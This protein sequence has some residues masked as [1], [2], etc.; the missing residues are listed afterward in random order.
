MVKAAAIMDA[1]YT[2]WLPC[3]ISGLNISGLTSC[4]VFITAM[5]AIVSF[6][7][8]GWCRWRLCTVPPDQALPLG[9]RTEQALPDRSTC[10]L[11]SDPTLTEMHLALLCQTPEA[12][13]MDWPLTRAVNSNQDGRINHSH[14]DRARHDPRENAG[15]EKHGIIHDQMLSVTPYQEYLPR[16]DQERGHE[17]V[18][19]LNSIEKDIPSHHQYAAMGYKHTLPENYYGTTATDNTYIPTMSETRTDFLE[20]R[21]IACAHNRILS[22]NSTENM[23]TNNNCMLTFN[24]QPAGSMRQVDIITVR[25]VY[26]SIYYAQKDDLLYDTKESLSC[27]QNS[28]STFVNQTPYSSNHQLP[29]LMS[30]Y[31]TLTKGHESEDLN[32]F[33]SMDLDMS[34]S[35]NLTEAAL[36]HCPTMNIGQDFSACYEQTRATQNVDFLDEEKHFVSFDQKDT[37]S[38][39]VYS[40][41]NDQMPCVYCTE[42]LDSESANQ[43]TVL[44]RKNDTPAFYQTYAMCS[45]QEEMVS[46]RNISAVSYNQ[47]E[48]SISGL[49]PPV[50][51]DP[52]YFIS[53]NHLVPI[54]YGQEENIRFE[55]SDGSSRHPEPTVDC[56]QDL[57]TNHFQE[58]AATCKEDSLGNLLRSIDALLALEAPTSI[59]NDREVANATEK[60]VHYQESGTQSPL[61]NTAGGADLSTLYHDTA[62]SYSWLSG[63]G[64]NQDDFQLNDE[65]ENISGTDAFMISYHQEEAKS[66]SQRSFSGYDR[67]DLFSSVRQAKADG[68]FHKDDDVC[69]D[70]DEER[71]KDICHQNSQVGQVQRDAQSYEKSAT[72]QSLSQAMGMGADD[73]HALGDSFTPWYIDIVG[74]DQTD[75]LD[76]FEKDSFHCN[77]EPATDSDYQPPSTFPDDK[78]ANRQDQQD[79]FIYHLD[80]DD[81]STNRDLNCNLTDPFEPKITLGPPKSLD[82]SSG[83]LADESSTQKYLSLD[84][85]TCDACWGLKDDLFVKEIVLSSDGQSPSK[86]C[87]ESLHVDYEHRYIVKDGQKSS[88]NDEQQATSSENPCSLKCNREDNIPSELLPMV[89]FEANYVPSNDQRLVINHDQKVNLECD[90]QDSL[91]P[92]YKSPSLKSERELTTSDV[93]EEFVVDHDYYLVYKKTSSPCNTPREATCDTGSVS[94][95]TKQDAASYLVDPT[96]SL[97]EETSICDH[98]E[99]LKSSESQHDSNSRTADWASLSTLHIGRNTEVG[100]R[101]D[102]GYMGRNKHEDET[103]EEQHYLSLFQRR[104]RSPSQVSK[105]NSDQSQVGSS[106][107]GKG[108]VEDVEDYAY[109]G[110]L[111]SARYSDESSFYGQKVDQLNDHKQTATNE[112]TPP[113]CCEQDDMVKTEDVFYEDQENATCCNKKNN[114]VQKPIALLNDANVPSV[115]CSLHLSVAFD[116]KDQVFSEH[117]ESSDNGQISAKSEDVDI[118]TED[119]PALLPASKL[120]VS[121]D[122]TRGEL[123]EVQEH[124]FT[125][126]Q[127]SKGFTQQPV[128]PEE[129]RDVL[130]YTFKAGDQV[131]LKGLRK[132]PT[133]GGKQVITWKGPYNICKIFNNGMCT[134][135]NKNRK[136]KQKHP[137]AD[138]QPFQELEQCM[139]VT[140]T[141]EFQECMPSKLE[142]ITSPQRCYGNSRQN[143]VSKG[144][145]S[146]DVS[147]GWNTENE[148]SIPEMY[149][150]QKPTK[151]CEPQVSLSEYHEEDIYDQNRIVLSG[152]KEVIAN[153]NTTATCTDVKLSRG[154]TEKYRERFDHQGIVWQ[155]WKDA[156]HDEMR[157][158]VR[159]DQSLPASPNYKVG[160]QVFCKDASRSLSKRQTKTEQWKGPYVI[161]RILQNNTVQLSGKNGLLRQKYPFSNL[162]PFQTP[163]S[164]K[165]TS[166]DSSHTQAAQAERERDAEI[167]EQR[168]TLNVDKIYLCPDDRKHAPNLINN[169]ATRNQKETRFNLSQVLNKV[170]YKHKADQSFHWDDDTIVYDGKDTV[171]DFKGL[172]IDHTHFT[173]SDREA[174]VT[175]YE[176]E[177]TPMHDFKVGDHVLLNDFKNSNK[178]KPMKAAEWKGPYTI[179]RILA[180]Q[181]CELLRNKRKLKHRHPLSQLKPFWERQT[182]DDKSENNGG[183][184][185]AKVEHVGAHD[186]DDLL[187][188]LPYEKDAGF[189]NHNNQR[190]S[191]KNAYVHDEMENVKWYDVMDHPEDLKE[192]M[193]LKGDHAENFEMAM[194]TRVDLKEIS[195]YSREDVGIDRKDSATHIFVDQKSTA[196]YC[197]K[198]VNSDKDTATWDGQISDLSDQE[199]NVL[200]Y[201]KGAISGENTLSLDGHESVMSY[202]ATS[203]LD[204][205]KYVISAQDNATWD[206]QTSVVSHQECSALDNQRD[207]IS[208]DDNFSLDVQRSLM[209]YQESPTPDDQKGVVS[210]QERPSLESHKSII[211]D[212]EIHAVDSQKGEVSGQSTCPLDDCRSITSHQESPALDN[213]TDVVSGQ[214]SEILD[215]ETP[216][217]DY[218]KTAILDQDAFSL[219]SQRS[220]ISH[221]E[222]CALDYQN[223][224]ISGQDTFSL[225]GQSSIIS[226]Q[227]T[228][229]L[230]RQNSVIT[231]QVNVSLDG[232]RSIISH[233]ETCSLD[234]QNSVITGQVNVSLDG[235]RSIISH[236][237]TCSLD[238]QNSVITGQVNVPLDGQRSRLSHQETCS[239]DRQN[240]VITGQDNFSLDGHRSVICQQETCSLDRQNSVIKGGHKSGSSLQ[241][242]CALD[243]QSNIICDKNTFPLDGHRSVIS[244]QETLALDYQMGAFSDQDTSSSDGKRSVM[245]HQ[246]SLALD[247]QNSAI[248][249]Q[250]TTS[251]DGQRSVMS[252]RKSPAVHYQ[253]SAISDQGTTSMDCQR[254]V[255][256]HQKTPALDYQISAISD[257]GTTSLDGQK[258]VKSHQGTPDLDPQIHLSYEQNTS[259]WD[260]QNSIT[261]PENTKSF[262]NWGM[263]AW[264]DQ[265]S[266]SSD[267]K[268]IIEN[269]KVRTSDLESSSLN[270]QN[271]INFD[272]HA[273]ELNDQIS[274]G[275]YQNTT[276]LDNQ[277]KMIF[278]KTINKSTEQKAQITDSKIF[279]SDDQNISGIVD[280]KSAMDKQYPAKS[281][282]QALDTSHSYRVGDRVLLNVKKG[283]RSN[284]ENQEPK[285]RGPYSIFKILQNNM[286]LL[287]NKTRQLKQKHPLWN[288]RPFLDSKPC[289]KASS[290]SEETLSSQ[291]LKQEYE[292]YNQ[293]DATKTQTS[294]LAKENIQCTFGEDMDLKYD[295]GANLDVNAKNETGHYKKPNSIDDQQLVI[296]LAQ[297]HVPS[298]DGKEYLGFSHEDVIDNKSGFLTAYQKDTGATGLA[299]ECNG[300]CALENRTSDQ[301][302]IPLNVEREYLSCQ[303][304]HEC[305]GV[306]TCSIGY[307]NK[308]LLRSSLAISK[309]ELEIDATTEKEL[310]IGDERAAITYRDNASLSK[311]QTTTVVNV[312]N[313]SCESDACE[314][315][316]TLD[317]DHRTITS[318]NQMQPLCSNESL[319]SNCHQQPSTCNELKRLTWNDEDIL[320]DDQRVVL[321]N[322]ASQ[323]S[324]Q[325]H[326]LQDQAHSKSCV[327]S[328]IQSFASRGTLTSNQDYLVHNAMKAICSG[329]EQTTGTDQVIPK[330]CDS[331]SSVSCGHQHDIGYGHLCNVPTDET[332]TSDMKLTLSMRHQHLEK[333][334]KNTNAITCNRTD[335]NHSG[336]QPV[337]AFA[338]F[339]TSNDLEED[340]TFS[341][342]DSLHHYQTALLVDEPN[343]IMTVDE[344]H[345]LTNEMLEDVQSNKNDVAINDSDLFASDIQKGTATVLSLTVKDATGF[346]TE[347]IM[348]VNQK[349]ETIS[350]KSDALRYKQQDVTG[351]HQKGLLDSDQAHEVR[352]AHFD[353]GVED[354]RSDR[355]IDG[356]KHREQDIQRDQQVLPAGEEQIV[357]LRS[358]QIAA[359]GTAAMGTENSISQ[360]EEDIADCCEHTPPV[361][362]DGISYPCQ[363]PTFSVCYEKQGIE[364][365]DMIGESKGYQKPVSWQKTDALK[366][367]DK[368]VIKLNQTDSPVSDLQH[369]VIVAPKPTLHDGQT[370]DVDSEKQS[371]QEQSLSDGLED[372]KH[373]LQRALNESQQ[374]SLSFSYKPGDQVLLRGV[375]KNHKGAGK[376]QVTW[377][378]PYTI[379]KVFTNSTC[380]LSNKN[381]N[382]SQKHPLSNL[383][384]FQSC[385]QSP[386]LR[387]DQKRLSRTPLKKDFLVQGHDDY[388]EENNRECAQTQIL[389]SEQKTASHRDINEICREN[390]VVLRQQNPPKYDYQNDE[391]Y[392]HNTMISYEKD[393]GTTS[394]VETDLK[395]VADYELKEREGCD[396]LRAVTDDVKDA[397]GE[398][399]AQSAKNDAPTMAVGHSHGVGDYVLYRE[400]QRSRGNRGQAM[401]VW[402]GPY[403]VSKVLQ[404]NMFQLSWKFKAL[405][406]KYP[407]EDLK[408]YEAPQ[409]V[410]QVASPCTYNAQPNSYPQR[411]VPISEQVATLDKKEEDCAIS[412]QNRIPCLVQTF[413][414]N[415][416][417]DN[418]CDHVQIVHA[419]LSQ[420]EKCQQLN[421]S[422]DRSF[423]EAEYGHIDPP[424]THRGQAHPIYEL[425]EIVSDTQDGKSVCYN[426]PAMINDCKP[427][428]SLDPSPTVH[429]DHTDLALHAQEDVG[430]FPQKDIF[431]RKTRSFNKEPA[432]GYGWKKSVSHNLESNQSLDHGLNFTEKDTVN[433]NHSGI[434]CCTEKQTLDNTQTM[435]QIHERAATFTYGQKESS[436]TELQHIESCL[437]EGPV[438]YEHRDV[439]QSEIDYVLGNSQ[440]SSTLNAVTGYIQMDGAC[441]EKIVAD[442]DE[443]PLIDDEQKPGAK[444]IQKPLDKKQAQILKKKVMGHVEKRVVGDTLKRISSDESSEEPTTVHSY[445]K[446]DRVLVKGMKRSHRSR[447]EPDMLWKGPYTIVEILP[448]SSCMLSIGKRILKPEFPLAHL[449]P[450]QE[451]PAMEI[452]ER[453]QSQ[454]WICELGLDSTH[455]EILLSMEWLDDK[456]IDAAQHLLKVQY[457]AKEGL[458]TT[459]LSCS[460][461]GFTPIQHQGVQ[462]HFDEIRNHWFTTS[463]S[464]SVVQLADSLPLRTLS[465]STQKQLKQCYGAVMLQGK[466]EVHLLSVDRQP[467]CD[468]C[469][470]YAIA[471]AVE[472][473]CS[474]G[475]PTAKYDNKAMRPHLITCLEKKKMAP[476]PKCPKL[477]R[478]S[479]KPTI[480][481]IFV[482]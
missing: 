399:V 137:L 157:T 244:Y 272:R 102:T 438:G 173:S 266:V 377:K 360:G 197:L 339:A 36:D 351:T 131:L 363:S 162:K 27:T 31:Q 119:I 128:S 107:Q 337:A 356:I 121:Y 34:V 255:M 419:S 79:D 329:E 313:Q 334:F 418:S 306:S 4:L 228:C 302:D 125:G 99:D 254:S 322:E 448:P 237:E 65:Q 291:E 413:V 357:V 208:D 38:G 305:E 55:Q 52:E 462:I 429:T 367:G 468:D 166:P 317:C 98:Q 215:Q 210:D 57:S 283:Q 325:E 123:N 316:H 218:Q 186:K 259:S 110:G 195:N 470:L 160:D 449:K 167:W 331:I 74:P 108:I 278:D 82:L 211:S 265:T 268:G 469:G 182:F 112:Q 393:A 340:L 42:N 80:D 420:H 139:P 349:E 1:H 103:F 473:L 16:H 397:T 202:Q 454:K 260:G 171:N 247:Y 191:E 361:K 374:D 177:V 373:R 277:N 189:P 394:A 440:S 407:A 75:F 249:D 396:Q 221:H 252:H 267:Q 410:P 389:S 292:K 207:V 94:S 459:L 409:P 352:E 464:G 19:G 398:D 369:D 304:A 467:N 444:F 242:S 437:L 466:L 77:L 443:K 432:E 355:N 114:A 384:L 69:K 146:Q 431:C 124:A 62:G 105:E 205:Q 135:C 256:S 201:K 261:F 270:N 56:E 66:N 428:L 12:H 269:Q 9:A 328:S 400:L 348:N 271:S 366:V 263:P 318:S 156:L 477:S 455:R 375:K 21:N 425:E 333:S 101:D 303:Q 227:E 47:I 130:S 43:D 381:R 44:G 253:N 70:S 147:T 301:K 78:P 476:F 179:I 54:K 14:G 284:E 421:L 246:K 126:K 158:K 416:Q 327:W 169:Y 436:N 251:M 138:L 289:A 223:S 472:F 264:N 71:C 6:L 390:S 213:M 354:E 405:K 275:S 196:E 457:G 319:A 426:V 403:I 406:K 371:I 353:V 143:D 258:S 336:V 342:K 296:N 417:E 15:G 149:L 184:S 287:L 190:R 214:N 85:H 142:E 206:G 309:M 219:D 17:T 111:P 293:K 274:L 376:Q 345:A 39:L 442:Y 372:V 262:F 151:N 89:T 447:G 285:W 175:G 401:N 22:V 450:F 185:P 341:N 298:C 297:K 463:Y 311:H 28:I 239:L 362:D 294:H 170:N 193:F 395:I 236:Q 104:L 136:L 37:H 282:D 386:T 148:D 323:N 97:D 446:G 13:E 198:D 382:L 81:D 187:Q 281:S 358:S 415:D 63:I 120:F 359:I 144:M 11:R 365:T 245:S 176:K 84:D 41:T 379:C 392:N 435:C 299:E 257:Q 161:S 423:L 183:L 96:L 132:T 385:Q 387:S 86:H 434:A 226:H 88:T 368:T 3:Y 461:E 482:Q 326:D 388:P 222:T 212:Q 152:A 100:A 203:V 59:Q 5:L 32:Y 18:E 433:V 117:R 456:I 452:I 312:Q 229:S 235:Q 72:C 288:L 20:N 295:E 140:P 29:P 217:L 411:S 122:Q 276:A 67:E 280:T 51:A 225:G 286:C 40:L 168:E 480:K 30:D 153:E 7:Y 404:N 460:A 343:S 165:S 451:S 58:S 159:Y 172:S 60:G 204:Y 200:Y 127:E 233:Q 224:V 53:C 25:Y 243:Y 458:Q 24:E 90:N 76:W 49:Q 95:T 332:S 250:G 129:Q 26:E 478:L 220:V 93:E 115:N 321:S 118:M 2:A 87:N 408:P 145:K 314:H 422:H 180:N 424:T 155:N 134:L 453:G 133:S 479:R 445:K 338:P 45:K 92:N 378:G 240:S 308:D 307:D 350:E 380:R 23:A 48:E 330:D 248:S 50:T 273:F 324:S 391:V 279:A 181:T 83:C 335:G 232:Q 199:S 61:P 412:D 68:P 10:V 64:Y 8:R 234:R 241:E 441:E 310:V 414:S 116:H 178:N 481:K 230:D 192:Y 106:I 364:S 163:Q 344:K 164:L 194:G 109:A 73:I 471:N 300:L 174:S 430:R 346:D 383:K 231:G 347:P 474:E 33:Q 46:C 35:S 216:A 113:I 427:A 465:V 154:N 91:V 290:I 315:K 320:C 439:G 150:A 402:K 475:T 188:T 209:S 370:F 238:R 141:P